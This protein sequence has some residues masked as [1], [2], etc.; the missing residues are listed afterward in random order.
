MSLAV[1][2]GTALRSPR[3]RFMPSTSIRVSPLDAHQR[4]FDLLVRRPVLIAFD[5]RG[6]PGCPQRLMALDELKAF[7]LNRDTA[8]QVRDT[9]WRELVVRARRDGA[10]WG[11]GAIGIAM[12]GLRRRAGNIARGF[13]GDVEDIDAEMLKTFWEQLLERVDADQRRVLG[14]MLDAAERAGL[15]IRYADVTTDPLDS[16]PAGP[17]TPLQPWDHPDFVL[18]RAVAI[19]VIDADDANIIAETRLEG[20]TVQV[21]AARR[22]IQGQLAS[23]WRDQAEKRL[24]N[25]IR[26]GE[27]AHVR[28]RP[29]PAKPIHRTTLR[30]WPGE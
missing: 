22:G 5:G 30:A 8:P 20:V 2:V 28:L 21:A 17:R 14:R 24:I 15:K 12:P 27:L 25:A 18:A 26:K 13:V 19:G 4:A 6:I 9:V 10:G 23:H 16:E 3:E 7:L 1:P 11:I 29:H